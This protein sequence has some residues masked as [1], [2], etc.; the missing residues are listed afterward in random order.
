VPAASV[1]HLEP[2]PFASFLATSACDEFVAFVDA[3]LLLLRLDKGSEELAQALRDAASPKGARLEPTLGFQTHNDARADAAMHSQRSPAFNA[4]QVALRLVR[5]PNFAIPVRKRPGAGKAFTERVSVGR[6]RNNDVVLRHE[7][8]SKFHAW[9]RR[10]EE[11]H[12]YVG[13]AASRNGT[14]VNGE[15][16]GAPRLLVPGDEISFGTLE[17]LFCPA[18]VLWEAIHGTA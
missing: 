18:E 13:D 8:I 4:G 2:P 7:S 1:R 3:P 9:F 5:G 11:G 6:A 14:R 16:L 15:L 10:D 12:F 17:A